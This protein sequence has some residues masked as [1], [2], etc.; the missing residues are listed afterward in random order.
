[1]R[2]AIYVRVS[3]TEQSKKFSLR[4]QEEALRQYSDEEG[5]E[6]VRVYAD[7]CSGMHWEGQTELM[8][9]IQAAERG[10]FGVLAITERD[11]LTRDPD[12]AS[13]L[14]YIF[15]KK[16][17]RLAVLNEPAL[18]SKNPSEELID[19][20]ISLIARYESQIRLVR[21]RRGMDLAVKSGKHPGKAPLG[22]VNTPDGLKID[23]EGAAQVRHIFRE[24]AAGRSIHALSKEAGLNPSKVHY[25]LN[26]P[27]Y[28]GLLRWHGGTVDGAHPPLISR[29]LWE[30]A[31]GRRGPGSDDG[32]R[33]KGRGNKD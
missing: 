6:V 16:G 14:K 1:M 31:R 4:A 29:E 2:A 24:H 21:V 12:G 30:R 11:R 27:A 25:I 15:A 19:G 8:E 3:T 23:R 9:L 7:Q 26:N 10:E 28:I 13:I 5:L 18:S 20:I 32:K 22:Y 17:V 33:I